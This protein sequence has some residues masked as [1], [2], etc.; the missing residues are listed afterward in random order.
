MEVDFRAMSAAAPAAAEPPDAKK[1]KT[2][3][4]TS[5]HVGK[6]QADNLDYR[7]RQIESQIGY[8]FQIT[9]LAAESNDLFVNLINAKK[10][11]RAKHPGNKTPHHMGHE[12]ITLAQSVL[13]VLSKAENKDKVQGWAR[14]TPDLIT[15]A[16]NHDKMASAV[17]KPSPE[18]QYNALKFYCSTLTAENLVPELDSWVSTC[19]FTLT[20]KKEH[21][22]FYMSARPGTLQAEFMPLITFV[23]MGIGALALQGTAPRGPLFH[24]QKK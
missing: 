6:K 18:Q 5:D 8:T 1:Q 11:W 16:A 22:L 24:Q 2:G 4:A 12:K 9:S 17:M 3:G 7:V 19:H 10:V 13:Q 14:A 23:T 15:A 20:E 21:Y